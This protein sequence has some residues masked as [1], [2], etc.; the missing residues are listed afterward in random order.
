MITLSYSPWACEA[1]FFYSKKGG[2]KK[3]G[4]LADK[5]RYCGRCLFLVEDRQK[6]SSLEQNQTLQKPKN[7]YVPSDSDPTEPNATA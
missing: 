6:I 3:E 4:L 1:V 2:D 5:Q 7:A